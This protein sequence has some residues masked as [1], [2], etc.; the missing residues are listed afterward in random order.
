MIK[1][2]KLNLIQFVQKIIYYKENLFH[3]KKD[4]QTAR[5]LKA[6]KRMFKYLF[7]SEG[8]LKMFKNWYKN[9][10]YHQNLNFH[11]LKHI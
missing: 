2:I 3:I 1:I 6:S 5:M 11:H 10:N 8:F 9:H 7:L 4:Q